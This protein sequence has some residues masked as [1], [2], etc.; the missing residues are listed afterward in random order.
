MVVEAVFFVTRVPIFYIHVA[1]LSRSWR[2]VVVA[3]VD[4]GTSTRS[5]PRCSVHYLQ[6]DIVEMK[7]RSYCSHEI[8]VAMFKWHKKCM[9]NAMFNV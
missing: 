5:Q 6:K 4:I 9:N 7:N 1:D 2:L 8:L 3:I